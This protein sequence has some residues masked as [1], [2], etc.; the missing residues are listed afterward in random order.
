MRLV[1][2]LAECRRV[3]EAVGCIACTTRL[4]NDKLVKGDTVGGDLENGRSWEWA[5]R[6]VQQAVAVGVLGG[7]LCNTVANQCL[8]T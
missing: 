5:T 4:A 1:D 2:A 6:R 8:L 3:D 7:A